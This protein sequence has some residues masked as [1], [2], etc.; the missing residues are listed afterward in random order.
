MRQIRRGVI[1]AVL[2]PALAGCSHW[3]AIGFD[4]PDFYAYQD[5]YVDKAAMGD[6]RVYEGLPCRSRAPYILAGPAG[7]AGPLLS[8]ELAML[9]AVVE[10]LAAALPAGGP[11]AG[12]STL[13]TVTADFAALVAR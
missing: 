4:G 6:G 13:A 9:A 11:D 3:P 1:I 7:A 5:G 2:F 8:G 10:E 12:G